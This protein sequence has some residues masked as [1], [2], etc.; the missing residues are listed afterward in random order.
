M[1]LLIRVFCK[2]IIQ[3]Y[4]ILFTNGRIK[5]YIPF[6]LKM[7]QGVII[8]WKVEVSRN[9]QSIGRHTFIHS[10]VKIEPSV[11]TIGAFCSISRGVKIGLGAHP[12][13]RMS[14]SPLFYDN[15][16]GFVNTTDYDDVAIVG[17]T[18]IENDVLISSDVCILAGVK[19][20]TGAIIGAGAVVVNDI[21]PYAIAVGVP[22]RVIGFRFNS[23]IIDRLLNSAWWNLPLHEIYTQYKSFG[24]RDY[25]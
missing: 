3:L 20:H 16:R 11:K 21:P 14:T 5:S 17:D 1:I 7:G 22:A 9:C 2:K 13:N 24:V 10:D 19:I 4:F 18:V 12:K 15:S 23:E 6:T 25:V 8:G